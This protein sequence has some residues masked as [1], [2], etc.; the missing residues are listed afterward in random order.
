MMP[1]LVV[2][3]LAAIVVFF[4]LTTIV[5]KL[6]YVSQPNEALIFSGRVRRVGN[7]ELGY[8]VSWV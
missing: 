3:A 6:L 1:V 4:T 2:L 5:K 8:R 7:K